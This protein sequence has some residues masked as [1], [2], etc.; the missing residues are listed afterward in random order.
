MTSISKYWGHVSFHILSL[1]RY[2]VKRPQMQAYFSFLHTLGQEEGRRKSHVQRELRKH[3][4]HPEMG[5]SRGWLVTSPA[6]LRLEWTAA[7]SGHTPRVDPTG[8]HPGRWREVGG[9]SQRSGF[10]TGSPHLLDEV[11]M[12]SPTARAHLQ[13]SASTA[14][15][16]L[17][18]E[19]EEE[20]GETGGGQRW[21]ADSTPKPGQTHALHAAQPAP[22][23]SFLGWHLPWW[24][25]S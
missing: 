5:S 3:L 22:N 12:S 24:V 17:G 7:L 23:P 18:R 10:F 21:G 16:Q 14:A 6:S 13:A 19:M 15:S 2:N 25:P 4:A 9:T 1:A 8:S 20:A 11:G